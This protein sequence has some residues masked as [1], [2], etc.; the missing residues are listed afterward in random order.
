M[1]DDALFRFEVFCRSRQLGEALSLLT[2]KVVEISPPQLVHDAE[3]RNGKL[4]F[5]S[6]PRLVELFALY[7]KERKLAKTP[8]HAQDIREFL[9]TLGYSKGSYSHYLNMIRDAGLVRKKGDGTATRWH[10]QE[11]K[12]AKI[13]ATAAPVAKEEIHDA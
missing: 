4:R 12:L 7:V 8:L 3:Q 10:V 6:G 2:G 1:A 11:A 5:V 13:V 9:G